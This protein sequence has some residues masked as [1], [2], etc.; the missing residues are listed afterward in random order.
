MEEGWEA[1]WRKT[2]QKKEQ[3]LKEA[4]IKV[5]KEAGEEKAE[6]DKKIAELMAEDEAERKRLDDESERLRKEKA[7]LRNEEEEEWR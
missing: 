4:A 3:E 5:A 2:K 6:W 7:R 1:E